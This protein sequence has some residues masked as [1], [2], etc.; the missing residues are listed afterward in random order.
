MRRESKHTLKKVINLK[1][2]KKNKGTE[3][4]YAKGNEAD[5]ER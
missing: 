3:I 1:G 2:R 4:N 5:I